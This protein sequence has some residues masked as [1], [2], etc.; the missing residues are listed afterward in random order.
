MQPRCSID[1]SIA[2]RAAGKAG[3]AAPT[4]QSTKV[5][6]ACQ[7]TW[8]ST[9][10]PTTAAV[11]SSPSRNNSACCRVCNR[12]L[13]D[14]S[15]ATR[16]PR[17]RCKPICSSRSPSVRLATSVGSSQP[18]ALPPRTSCAEQRRRQGRYAVAL[19]LHH[20]RSA[21]TLATSKVRTRRT[22]ACTAAKASTRLMLLEWVTV[23]ASSQL[24][25]TSFRQSS[26]L[27]PLISAAAA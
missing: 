18:M 20:I 21:S 26:W 27:R 4:S 22:V 14:T 13:Y 19:R 8:A 16:L 2:S 23:F 6:S 15:R 11:S 7:A 1:P 24:A 9:G 17:Y 3:S 5:N 25:L 12:R 10:T